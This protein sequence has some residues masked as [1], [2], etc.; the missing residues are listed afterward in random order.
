MYKDMKCECVE[1]GLTLAW[2][3][4][5]WE[6][7]LGP[8]CCDGA[9]LRGSAGVDTD[10]SAPRDGRGQY[11]IS[12]SCEAGIETGMTHLHLWQVSLFSESSWGRAHSSRKGSGSVSLPS[13]RPS[14]TELAHAQCW[15]NSRQIKRTLLARVMLP[16]NNVEFTC[17]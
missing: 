14:Y 13:R 4:P 8:V 16:R 10:T 1:K 15:G 12:S 17:K 6:G 2:R 5:L 11:F 3:G 7:S 9:Q